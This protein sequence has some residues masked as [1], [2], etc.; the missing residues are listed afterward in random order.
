MPLGRFSHHAYSVI[1]FNHLTAYL[2]QLGRNG[3]QMLGNHVLNHDIASGGSCS[4]HKC[5]CLNLIRYNGILSA[6][7]TV[8]S[9]DTNCIRTGSLYIG[10]HAV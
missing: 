3:F 10:A 4:A 2:R 5:A 9:P 7:K 8:H 6:V 1:K